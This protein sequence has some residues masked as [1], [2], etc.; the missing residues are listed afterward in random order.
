MTVTP[1]RRF[2]RWL[3]RDRPPTPPREPSCRIEPLESE[4]G[5]RLEGDLDL[6]TVESLRASLEPELHGTL[7]LDLSGVGYID[8]S[9]LGL[10]VGTLKRLHQRNGRL[11]LRDPRSEIRRVF[12]VT[13]IV[14]LPG[15]SIEP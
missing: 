15:L 5:F 8:D 13:G 10:L 3:R 2:L 4:H 1:R 12:E 7:V 11:V 6:S 14:R 9:G